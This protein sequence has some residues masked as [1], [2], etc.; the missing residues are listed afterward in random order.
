MHIISKEIE[1]DF[2]HRVWTQNL[3]EEF[4]CTT[5]CK[6]KAL[7]GHRFKIVPEIYNEDGLQPDGMVT[8]F[9]HFAKF[10][11][12]VDTF[13]DHKMLMD[14]EDPALCR[15]FPRVYLSK[16]IVSK[17]E[18]AKYNSINT[19]ADDREIYDGLVIVEFVPTAENICKWL[20]VH[21]LPKFLPKGIKVKSLTFYE[22]PKSFA[23]WEN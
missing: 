7:H 16:E 4:A 9:N 5:S 14:A 22:T 8:D 23:R 10:K 6:C 18:A 13:M 11:N 2:G 3:D 15:F 19:T 12:W 21:I 1:G 20:A 17:Y